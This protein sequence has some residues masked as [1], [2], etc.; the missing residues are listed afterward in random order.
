MSAYLIGKMNITD[1]GRYDNYKRLTP[2]I[3]KAHGGRFISR[4]GQKFF[5]E[6]EAE[7]RR[8][9]LVEFPSVEAAQRF[10]DSEEYERARRLREGAADDMQLF[11]VEGLE[12]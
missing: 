8:V 2:E 12:P 7:S 1:Q 4:G 10:Y 3:V 5:L 11:I 9:V 6:G